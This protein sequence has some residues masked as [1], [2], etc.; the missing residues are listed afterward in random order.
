M[1]RPPRLEGEAEELAVISLL[2]S[3]Y[4]KGDYREGRARFLSK[5]HIV[6]SRGNQ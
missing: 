2:S 6:R 3:D 4:I 1:E 5:M